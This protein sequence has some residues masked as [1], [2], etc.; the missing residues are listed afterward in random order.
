MDSH[1]LKSIKIK[2]FHTRPGAIKINHCAV[3]KRQE[4]HYLLDL[5]G[6][7]MFNYCISA[8]HTRML[9]NLNIFNDHLA[10]NTV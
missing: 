4:Q 3:D 5:F 1:S 6:E 8:M 9:G 2:L 10:L 7:N